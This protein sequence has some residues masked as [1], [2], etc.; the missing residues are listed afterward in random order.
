MND[1]EIIIMN[2]KTGN[3]YYSI[4]N[5]EYDDDNNNS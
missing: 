2:I 3:N 5:I 1:I 4:N